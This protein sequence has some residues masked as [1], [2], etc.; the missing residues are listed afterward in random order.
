MS[1]DQELAAT[2]ASGI[3]PLIGGVIAVAVGGVIALF[4]AIAK[5]SAS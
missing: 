4:M 2:G 3:V 5:R 1:A